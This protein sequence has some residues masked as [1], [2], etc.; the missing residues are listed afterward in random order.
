MK[1]VRLKFTGKY[2]KFSNLDGLSNQ[3]YMYNAGINPNNDF[4]DDTSFTMPS[5]MND[6]SSDPFKIDLKISFTFNL[7]TKTFKSIF[8]FSFFIISSSSTASFIL[9]PM[10]EDNQSNHLRLTL[11][12]GSSKM[13]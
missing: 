12:T 11:L 1:D 10:D 13:I 3:D 9:I 6:D 2:A 5:K 4:G 8:Y 7:M